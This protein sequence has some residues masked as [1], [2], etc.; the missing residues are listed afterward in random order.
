MMENKINEILF[1][2]RVY[3]AGFAC[4]TFPNF[5]TFVDLNLHLR[6]M[7][8]QKKKIRQDMTTHG[9]QSHMFMS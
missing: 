6:H 5:F 2:L 4:Q 1:G 9:S 7:I 3:D 8:S